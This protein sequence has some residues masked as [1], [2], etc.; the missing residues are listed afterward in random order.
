MKYRRTIL[1]CSFDFDL[2]ANLF[3]F[4]LLLLHFFPQTHWRKWIP[5][6]MSH[7]WTKVSDLIP[8]KSFQLSSSGFAKHIQPTTEQN[9]QTIEAD[10]LLLQGK[11]VSRSKHKWTIDWIFLEL[12]TELEQRYTV[13]EELQKSG[14][15]Y[16][17]EEIEKELETLEK[18]Q[19]KF[20]KIEAKRKKLA[21]QNFEQ[22][23]SILLH[24]H[25]FPHRSPNLLMHTIRV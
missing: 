20:N 12:K 13:L 15:K 2:S 4:L 14:K 3:L 7:V 10:D 24:S 6:S 21:K 17:R 5:F 9:L 23:T 1:I 16:D 22:V 18:L 19:N 11:T 25:S 8:R